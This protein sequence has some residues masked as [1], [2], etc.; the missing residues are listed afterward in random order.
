MLLI[1]NGR[2]IDPVTKTDKM[3]DLFIKDGKIVLP[4]E[5]PENL[6]AVTVIDA[7]GDIVAPGLVDMHVHFRDP[8]FLYKE[9][10]FSG[11]EAA[12]AGGVTT[13]VCMPNTNPAIDSA[14]AVFDI[15]NRTKNTGVTILPYAAVTVGQ[16]GQILTD[17]SALKSA[18]AAALSDDGMPVMNAALL[19]DGMKMAKQHDMLISSH[20][21][22]ADLVK[23]HAVN[24]GVISE[25][26]G[27]PGRPAI[28]EELMVMRDILLAAD[29]GARLHIAHVSTAGSVEIIRRAKADGIRV[30]AET[31]PQYFTLTEEAVLTLGSMARVNPPLRTKKDMEAILAGLLDGTI[32]AV[33]TDH[34][35]HS[36]A[37][38][39]R[40]L[41]EALSGMVGLETSLGLT[42]TALFHTGLMP[43]SRIVEL[44]SSN[45]SKI[46]GINKGSL[47]IGDDADIVIFNPNITWTV[48][49]EKFRSKGRNTP[50]SGWTLKGKVR[51]TIAGGKLIYKGD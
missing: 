25:K 2:V 20:C 33:A 48:D 46:L 15:I 5:L 47:R 19:R 23:N 30:T 24:E 41:A 22:D 44:M 9:D 17:V 39:D 36:Q 28:A 42:L 12:A 8:G 21:E 35:P 27:L 37:E 31:C 4:G 18:G 11:A 38:K 3:T 40:P 34:A 16:K 14:E 29:T 43:L 51:Y 13:A 7:A 1:R 49:P 45:P 26:L 32:D 6:S 50:F 10:V